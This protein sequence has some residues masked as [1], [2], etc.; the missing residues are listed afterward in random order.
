[1]LTMTK[2]PISIANG[3]EEKTTFW[4]DF[5]VADRF[6]TAAI[7]DTYKRAFNG[8][9]DNVEYLTELALVLNHKIW[10]WHGKNDTFGRLYNELWAKTDTYAVENLKGDDLRY[11]LRTTD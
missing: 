3:Y 6:G 5:S 8:W 4:F 9:K 11:Y 1:M 2:D 7:K 10:Q